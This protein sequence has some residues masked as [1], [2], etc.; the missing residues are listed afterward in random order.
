MGYLNENAVY[1]KMYRIK[2][3]FNT[4]KITD[5]NTEV[6]KQLDSIG[7]KDTVKKDAHIG[8]TCGSRGINNIP[9][10]IKAVVHYVKSIGAVPFIIPAMGS[11]GGAEA[12]GQKHV[13]EKF[14]V[15]EEAMGCEIRSSMDTVV[16]GQTPEGV[17]VYFDKNA[18]E[19]D[20]VIVVNRVK[21]HTDF[22]AKNESGLVKM[23]SV[24][25]GKQKGASAMHDNGLGKTIPAAA[26]VALEKAPIIA[27]LAI[28]EN[29][30]EDTCVL[31]AVKPE[32]FIEDDAKLLELSNSLVPSLPVDYI[33]IL[34]VKEMGKQYSGTGMD[35]K[36]IGR[37]KIFG[38][39]EPVSPR[40]K[41][42]AVLRLSSASY[43]NALGIGLA[44]LTVK[45]LV[46][47]I[48][49][50]A[51]YSNL[52]TTTFLE[53]GKVPVHFDT[54]KEVIDVA[55]RTI[56]NVKPEDARVMIIENTLNIGTML[57]S[58]S[59]YKDIKDRVE[60]VDEDVKIKFNKDLE[61]DV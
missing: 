3:K 54:E 29:A 22:T 7:L 34:I 6:I 60:L 21:R 32:N 12:E 43:G 17:N 4:E 9:V 40:I 23:I 15:S 35:T 30:A 25:L 52:V 24:G 11:H 27:G 47:S 57:V 13:C 56:G 16:L 38:E 61:L 50:E 18:Y 5:I 48:D 20:G 39:K 59:I 55:L 33:D 41:K 51:M 26:K 45:K 19:S 1:P 31:K 46:D 2:Q 58:E 49:Y 14:G 10:I 44:D 8:I 36:V 42:L 37:M 28:V 53:R